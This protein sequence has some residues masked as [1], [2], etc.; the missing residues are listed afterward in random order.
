MELE[1]QPERKLAKPAL[2][3][4]AAE[5]QTVEAALL[6]YDIEAGAGWPRVV[7][8][9]RVYIEVMVIEYVEAFGPEIQ[10]K[11]LGEF[12][13]FADRKIIVPGT[14]GAEGSPAG[15]VAR[16]GAEIGN[17]QGWIQRAD[18]GGSGNAQSG[19]LIGSDINWRTR[20]EIRNGC[21]GCEARDAVEVDQVA[22]VVDGK[23]NSGVSREYAGDG[24]ATQSLSLDA[25]SALEPR[26]LPDRRYNDAMTNVKIRVAPVYPRI[27]EVGVARRALGQIVGEGCA[28]VVR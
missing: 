12:E 19:K 14:W 2:V 4:V 22:F 26:S 15:H 28:K 18:I 25:L 17:T 9:I 13:L 20:V 6:L 11:A 1:A 7:V 23:G 10:I 21:C 27:R 5:S 8:I 24:P 16:I 3:V